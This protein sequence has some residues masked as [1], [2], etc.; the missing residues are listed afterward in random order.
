MYQKPLCK[1]TEQEN[2]NK[3]KG[4]QPSKSIMNCAQ[5]WIDY[6]TIF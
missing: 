4:Y 6:V 3:E 1:K 5:K 2:V